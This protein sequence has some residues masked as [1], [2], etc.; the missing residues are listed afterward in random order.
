MGSEWR[1]P[2]PRGCARSTWVDLSA[3]KGEAVV[4]E[5]KCGPHLP[6]GDS[7]SAD[8]QSMLAFSKPV[9]QDWACLDVLGLHGRGLVPPSN[10]VSDDVR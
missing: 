9:P 3:E 10:T 8:S 1:S 5:L 2:T 4:D 6:L 7:T